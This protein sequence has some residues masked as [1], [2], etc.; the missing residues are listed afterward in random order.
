MSAELR[1]ALSI[2]L[3]VLSFVAGSI[4]LFVLFA[5]PRTVYWISSA[6]MSPHANGQTCVLCG[7]TRALVAVARGD[8]AGATAMNPLVGWLVVPM[9]AHALWGLYESS[10][11]FVKVLLAR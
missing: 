4:V 11:W 2:V 7:M 8:L 10:K 1:K 3:R 9:V 6:L 5:P